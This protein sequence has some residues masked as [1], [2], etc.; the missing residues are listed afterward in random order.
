[1][2]YSHLTRDDR[3]ELGA[4]RR[5]GYGDSEVAR[6]LGRAR[7]TI[8]RERTRNQHTNKSGYHARV[9]HPKARAR[10]HQANQRFRKITPGTFLERYCQKALACELSPEQIAG[11]LRFVFGGSQIC[12]ETIY[13]WVYQIHPELKPLLARRGTKYRRRRGT[14]AKEQLRDYAKKR[15]ITERPVVV[16]DRSRIGDW[17]GDTVVGLAGSGYLATLVERKSGYLE[18]NKLERATAEAMLGV[19]TQHLQGAHTLTLDNGSE[20]A[21]HEEMERRTGTVVY[22]A[23]PYHSWERGTNENTNGL[24]R[25]YFPKKTS[26]EHITQEDVDRVVRRINTRPRKRLGYMSPHTVFYSRVALRSRI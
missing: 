16:R 11:K 5:A 7:T 17:E 14:R 8:W 13:Q 15:W 1:M 26:F 20:M 10:R 9:A 25:R 21:Y 24:L 2:S 6:Q 4:L 23:Y 3:V 22:F 19:V 18:A 12:H